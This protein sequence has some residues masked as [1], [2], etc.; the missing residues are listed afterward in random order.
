MSDH[1]LDWTKHY[2][3]SQLLAS[4]KED[5]EIYLEADDKISATLEA[6]DA[7]SERLST[8][9]LNQTLYLSPLEVV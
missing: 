5:L 9:S 7:L 1:R 8:G 3:S 4:I 2:S 6:I